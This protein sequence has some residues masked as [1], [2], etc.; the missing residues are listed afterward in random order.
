MA[1]PPLQPAFVLHRRRYGDTSLLVELLTR[2]EGRL[3]AVARGAAQSRS[4]RAGLLQ[5]FVPLLVGMRGRGEVGT[6]AGVEAAGRPFA[7]RGQALYCGL[8]L[9]ELLLRLLVRGDAQPR[10]FADYLHTLGELA[11]DAAPDG[12]LRRFELGLLQALGFALQLTL[13]ADGRTPVVANGRYHYRVDAGP[14]PAPHDGSYSGD[15]LL[16]LE[17][18]ETL[19][20]PARNEAR[21]LM[22]QVLDHYLGGRPLRSRELFR[23]NP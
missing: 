23:A 22:R 16:R 8:Y 14:V 21:Q 18:G 4:G 13:E 12:P 20:G 15:M 6:L 19:S 1:A 17:R 5:A 11:T 3:V 10:L 7:L 2:D 9:N